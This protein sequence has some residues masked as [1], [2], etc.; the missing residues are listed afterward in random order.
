[1]GNR[2]KRTEHSGPKKGRGA[3]YS[4]KKWA[5]RDSAIKRRQNDRRAVD[6]QRR[7]R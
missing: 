7:G 4:R 3:Y 2:A 5:K 6:E 1:M